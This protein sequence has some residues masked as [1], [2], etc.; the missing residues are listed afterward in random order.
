MA[1]ALSSMFCDSPATL[2]SNVAMLRVGCSECPHAGDDWSPS[3]MNGFALEVVAE[4]AKRIKLPIR[5]EKVTDSAKKSLASGK[6]DLWPRLTPDSDD[7]R[8][9]FFSEPWVGMSF[10]FLSKRGWKPH[11]G[12]KVAITGSDFLARQVAQSIPGAEAVPLKPGERLMGQVCSGGAEAAFVESRVLYAMLL[13]D[14]DHQCEGVQFE[15]TPAKGAALPA[16]IAATQDAAWAARLLREEIGH[17]AADGS[18]ANFHAKWFLI[19]STETEAFDSLRH[20]ERDLFAIRLLACGFAGL[21]VVMMLQARRLRKMRADAERA[22]NLKTRFVAN[23]SHELRTPLSGIVGL[24]D[25]LSDTRLTAHQSELLRLVRS[26][27]RSLVQTTNDLLDVAKVQAGQLDVDRGPFDLR[28]TAEEVCAMMAGRAVEKGIKLATSIDPN[29]P[30]RVEGDA[31]RLR[32]V[33]MNL[34]GNALQ[35]TECGEVKLAVAVEKAT[36]FQWQIEFSISDTGKGIPP[37]DLPRL[38]QD[39]EQSDVGREP[40]RRGAGLGLAMGKRLVD[41][42]GGTIAVE[43]PGGVGAR[44]HF[45]LP[46]GVAGPDAGT[47]DQGGPSAGSQPLRVLVCE[48]DPVNQRVAVHMLNKLSHHVVAVANGTDAVAA[49]AS[50]KF[51]VVL[52]DCQLPDIDGY[53]AARRIRAGGA[54]AGARVVALTAAPLEEDRVHCREAGMEGFLAK[55]LSL[56]AL[57]EALSGSDSPSG[58]RTLSVNDV[59]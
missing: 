40:L 20:A 46:F 47:P 38:F 10:C 26:T 27:A 56:L 6:I 35:F 18:L 36:P 4:A 5:F 32:Q 22:S 9:V 29:V 43:S 15:T 48:D 25:M 55:P 3:P 41:L 8:D 37:E 1:A 28:A 14:R 31:T 11:A 51:D 7:R 33:L 52:M 30:R 13:N 12:A 17:M 45:T 23:V 53:E 16:S 50:E 39:F 34:L 44:F 42:M 49:A 2:P 59:Y 54:S 21:L 57:S 24:A 58:D 19:T